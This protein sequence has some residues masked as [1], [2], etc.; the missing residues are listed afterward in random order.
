MTRF[1]KLI[2]VFVGFSILNSI[3]FPELRGGLFYIFMFFFV[4]NVESA[5]LDCFVRRSDLMSWLGRLISWLTCGLWSAFLYAL[6]VIIIVFV[7]LIL[8]K[9][10]VA[11]TFLWVDFIVVVALGYMW[12][13]FVLFMKMRSDGR[14]I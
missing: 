2:F 7:D 6:N 8:L 10:F 3:A 14:V 9:N 4:A 5:W 11:R 1:V 12:A 13:V